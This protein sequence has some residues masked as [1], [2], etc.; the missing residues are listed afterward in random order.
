MRSGKTFVAMVAFVVAMAGVSAWACDKPKPCSGKKTAEVASAELVKDGRS[1]SADSA[2]T[3]CSHGAKTATAKSKTPCSH[4]AKTASTKAPCGANCDENCA[5]NCPHAKTRL[6][7]MAKADKPCNNREKVSAVLASMPTIKYRVGDETTACP[8]HAKGLAGEQ[9]S[10]QYVV[11]DDVFSSEDQAVEKLA[12]IMENEV[13]KLQSVHFVVADEE[14]EC[15]MTAKKVAAKKHGKVA[16]RVAGF[17]FADREQADKAVELVKAAASKVKM[18]YK[19]GDESFCCDRMAGAKAKQ[20]HKPIV[21][22]V[23][24]ES[25]PCAV[26]AKRLMAEAKLRAVIETAAEQAGS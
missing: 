13:N 15:P 1:E 26:T 8:K 19:V 23:N 10:I 24:G 16:Y 17:D 22:D 11:G 14:F 21:Y 4:G 9:G 7:A 25:T 12:A 6:A 2:K 20:T 18:Q 3:P 5:K